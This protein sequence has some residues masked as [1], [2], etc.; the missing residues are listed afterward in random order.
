[1]L[2]TFILVI[3]GIIKIFKGLRKNNVIYKAGVVLIVPVMSGI[4]IYLSLF[5]NEQVQWMSNLNKIISGRL[6]LGY[7]AFETYGIRLLGQP[8]QWVGGAREYIKDS[9]K[10]NYVD[11]SYIQILINYGIIIFVLICLLFV[12]LGWK[13]AKTNDIYLMLILVTIAMHS[14]LDP[15]LLW[16]A[17]NPFIMCYSYFRKSDSYTISRM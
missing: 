6:T 12:A 17:F 16:M 7:N 4:M 15:Q 13:A 11:S 10:Y 8:I 3:V 2:G 14:A 9:G 5:Y 1:M